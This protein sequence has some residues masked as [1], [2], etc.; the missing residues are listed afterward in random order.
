MRIQPKAK[1]SLLSIARKPNRN[2]DIAPKNKASSKNKT[3][4]GLKIE[5]VL[6]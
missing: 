6:L 2:L 5:W 1:I 3:G 4:P